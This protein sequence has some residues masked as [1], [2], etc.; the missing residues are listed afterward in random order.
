MDTP[1]GR[2]PFLLPPESKSPGGPPSPPASH[3]STFKR[4]PTRR[5]LSQ[6]ITTSTCHSGPH[7]FYLQHVSP[8]HAN[9]IY[10]TYA[11]TEA[12]TFIMSDVPAFLSHGRAASSLT[13]SEPASVMFLS[14]HSSPGTQ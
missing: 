2:V 3:I 5:V 7:V 14:S 8:E 10:T 9:Y 12:F 1:D 13:S 4:H 6:P 11:D